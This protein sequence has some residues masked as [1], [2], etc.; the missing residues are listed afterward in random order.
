M[1]STHWARI[2]KGTGWAAFVR[3]SGACVRAVD[4]ATYR[5]RNA[6][7]IYSPSFGV[8]PDGRAYRKYIVGTTTMFRSVEVIKPQRITMA[9]GV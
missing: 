6:D 8:G 3:S 1:P 4:R 2:A 7:R 5:A 9:I